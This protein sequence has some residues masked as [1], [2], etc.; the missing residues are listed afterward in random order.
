MDIVGHVGGRAAGGQVG[1]VAQGHPG[2]AG[3]H[4][5]GVVVLPERKSNRHNK[6]SSFSGIPFLSWQLCM[7]CGFI[8]DL[9]RVSKRCRERRLSVACRG[10]Y[11]HDLL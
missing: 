7:R 3:R 1:V 9:F 10:D 8:P 11:S 6:E 4:G 5:V 2:A